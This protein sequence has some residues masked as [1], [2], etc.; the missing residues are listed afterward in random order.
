MFF[1]YLEQ[2]GRQSDQQQ[3]AGLE[4]IRHLLSSTGVDNLGS[5]T[6]R[7]AGGTELLDGVNDVEAAGDL[8]E[9]D[10]LAVE[11]AGDDGGDEELGAV[12]ATS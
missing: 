2:E 5:A 7:A 12:A 10:V 11:P 3:I 4:V 9:D 8:A 6:D 1:Y